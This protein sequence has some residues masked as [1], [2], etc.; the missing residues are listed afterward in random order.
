MILLSIRGSKHLENMSLLIG[1]VKQ[2]YRHMDRP[3][4]QFSP[5]LLLLE[6]GDEHELVFH[7]V[8]NAEELDPADSSLFQALISEALTSYFRQWREKGL[9]YDKLLHEYGV[10]GNQLQQVFHLTDYYL[11]KENNDSVP[12]RFQR[13]HDILL[14]ILQE[15]N[16]LDFNGLLRFRLR[17]YEQELEE[18]MEIAQQEWLLYQEYRHVPSLAQLLLAL[19]HRQHQ[20]L[21]LLHHRDAWMTFYDVEYQMV[22]FPSTFPWASWRAERGLDGEEWLS[23]LLLAFSPTQIIVHTKDW[24]HP[25]IQHLHHLFQQ[26]FQICMGCRFCRNRGRNMERST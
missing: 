5:Q 3:L 16:H 9:L 17:E 25:I 15:Y 18:A 20:L 24:H 1:I 26:R 6:H 19:P 8:G 2:C 7:L 4:K 11:N 13:L 21:H 22:Q 10:E 23:S 12:W 14:S